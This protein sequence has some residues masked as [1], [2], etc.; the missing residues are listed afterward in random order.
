MEIATRIA[1]IRRA[2]DRPGARRAAGCV[3]E[4]RR[5][6]HPVA[7]K[8]IKDMWAFVE[9]LDRWHAQMLTVPKPKLAALIRLGTRVVGLL[10]LGKRK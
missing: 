5:P 10:P 2:R 8:R 3:V 1:A 4:R 7:A 6:R 9:M